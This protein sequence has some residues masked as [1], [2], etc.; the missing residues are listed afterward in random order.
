MYS[1]RI[2]FDNLHFDGGAICRDEVR[3]FGSTIPPDL[4]L[5]SPPNSIRSWFLK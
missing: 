2:M 5:F 4:G 3:R 1:L